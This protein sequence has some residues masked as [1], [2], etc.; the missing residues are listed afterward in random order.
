MRLERVTT[1]V[2]TQIARVICLDTIMIG[3]SILRKV[4]L[5]LVIIMIRSIGQRDIMI[6]TQDVIAV[7]MIIERRRGIDWGNERK[8]ERNNKFVICICLSRCFLKL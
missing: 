5:I 8:K 4:M 3:I 7:S 2:G 6:G 1:A